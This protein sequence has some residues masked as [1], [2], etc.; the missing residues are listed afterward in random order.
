M[1]TSGIIRCRE[2]RKISSLLR[3]S[4]I[5]S[6]GLT[7]AMVAIKPSVQILLLDNLRVELETTTERTTT[8]AAAAHSESGSS[9]SHDSL[10]SGNRRH[11]RNSITLFDRGRFFFQIAYVFVI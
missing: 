5:V 10:A 6:L 8:S 1:P 9:L 11:N 4:G 7:S 2:Y 3:A